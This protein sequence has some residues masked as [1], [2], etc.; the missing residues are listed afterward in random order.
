MRELQWVLEIIWSPCFI[1]YEI[2]VQ[3][4]EMTELP[5][6][7]YVDPEWIAEPFH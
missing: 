7:G 2:E 1:D 6:C 3:K 5:N 4:I